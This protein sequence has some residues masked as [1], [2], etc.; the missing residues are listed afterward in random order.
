MVVRAALLLACSSVAISCGSNPS[1]PPNYT[2]GPN[3]SSTSC[4][5]N[6]GGDASCQ[7]NC[8]NRISTS[9]SFPGAI[10]PGIGH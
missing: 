7:M 5:D 4:F 10:Q 2:H 3:Y 9:P 1:T 6:C 8:T